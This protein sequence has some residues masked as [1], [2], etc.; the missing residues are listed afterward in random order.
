MRCKNVKRLGHVRDVLPLTSGS[1]AKHKDGL[2]L[3]SR[4][5]QAFR[6]MHRQYHH[7]LCAQQNMTCKTCWIIGVIVVVCSS[8][9]I[10]AALAYRPPKIQGGPCAADLRF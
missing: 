10:R 4:S 3:H 8:S 9:E 5:I 2:L 7:R 6:R 1:T